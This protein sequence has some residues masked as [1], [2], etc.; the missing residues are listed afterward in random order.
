MNNCLMSVSILAAARPSHPSS[1]AHEP[2]NKPTS[3]HHNNHCK[4]THAVAANI[5]CGTKEGGMYKI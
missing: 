2:I 5:K 3:T 4:A 1:S